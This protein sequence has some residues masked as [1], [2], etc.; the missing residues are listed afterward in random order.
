M[1]EWVSN[2][3]VHGAELVF[4]Y[5]A[6]RANPVVGN[7]FE[8]CSWCYT[9]FRIAYFWVVHPATYITYILFHNVSF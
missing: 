6:Q 5:S 4:A 1:N 8:S 9:A 3:S 2:L 7:V